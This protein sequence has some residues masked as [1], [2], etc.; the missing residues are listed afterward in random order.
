MKARW[1]TPEWREKMHAAVSRPRPPIHPVPQP[2]ERFGR[3]LVIGSGAGLVRR[4]LLCECSCGVRKE[5]ERN[6]LRTG[7]SRSCGCERLELAAAARTIALTKPDATIRSAFR[8]YRDGAKSRG[9]EFALTMNDIATLTQKECHYC[10]EPPT[11][12]NQYGSRHTRPH[13][14]NGIDRVNNAIGYTPENSVACCLRCNR[15]KGS[16]SQS[17]FL[18]MCEAVAKHY[19]SQN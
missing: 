14:G 4:G 6:S 10:G 13:I 1:A 7:L 11:R 18:A 3:W 19:T 9:L 5:V 17:E 2:G 16:H 8:S 15:G 12:A